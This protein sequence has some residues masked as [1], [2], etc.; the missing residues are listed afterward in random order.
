MPA[1]EIEPP[2]PGSYMHV[3]RRL[4]RQLQEHAIAVIFYDGASDSRWIDLDGVK[5]HTLFVTSDYQRDY[6]TKRGWEDVTD[7]WFASLRSEALADRVRDAVRTIASPS[8]AAT[9]A[10]L[11][12]ATAA[13]VLPVLESL[14]ASGDAI[15]RGS[16]AVV[17]WSAPLPAVKPTEEQSAAP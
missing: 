5:A 7:R 12:D 15:R 14:A 11:V 17:L 13:E 16:G 8:T 10:K 2:V 1:I 4:D 9:V 3:L 6:A